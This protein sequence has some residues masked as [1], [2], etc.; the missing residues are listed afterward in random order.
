LVQCTELVHWLLLQ[1]NGGARILFDPDFRVFSLMVAAW[2]SGIFE[3]WWNKRWLKRSDIHAHWTNGSNLISLLGLNYMIVWY[4][5]LLCLNQRS[6]SLIS[7]TFENSLKI[8]KRS[9]SVRIK[10]KTLKNCLNS[11][12]W[13]SEDDLPT[14]ISSDLY[15]HKD[16]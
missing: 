10:I 3:Y 7:K 4:S 8:I 12:I 5:S 2:R 1:A 9:S 15:S 14:K 13:V 11:T 6:H 16:E